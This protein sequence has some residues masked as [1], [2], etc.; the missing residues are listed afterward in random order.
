MGM[1]VVMVPKILRE[2]FGEDV[3]EALAEFVARTNGDVKRDI[4]E[5][6]TERLDARIKL[7]EERFERRLAE[8]IGQLRVEMHALRADI[9]KWMFLFWVGQMAAFL[10]LFLN[11]R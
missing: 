3:A 7:A 4:L 11:I 5:I 8:E 10:A 6:F 1:A 9:I 2:K